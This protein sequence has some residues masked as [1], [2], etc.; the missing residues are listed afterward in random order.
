VIQSRTRLSLLS[1]TASYVLPELEDELVQALKGVEHK[2]ATAN[3]RWVE[4]FVMLM[5]VSGCN[6][7]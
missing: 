1:A 5:E 4:T 2:H 6:C 3:I 7:F